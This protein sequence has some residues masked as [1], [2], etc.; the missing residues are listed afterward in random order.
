MER[1]IFEKGMNKGKQ[2]RLRKITLK[3]ENK[4]LQDEKLKEYHLSK[5]KFDNQAK[6]RKR[7]SAVL[8]KSRTDINMPKV[9]RSLVKKMA[10]THS[11]KK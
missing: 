10:V 4:I 2:K 1:K 8:T 5:K 3:E 9:K 7:R 11:S 6:R